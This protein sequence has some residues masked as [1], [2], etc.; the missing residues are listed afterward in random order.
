MFMGRSE[1]IPII[2]NVVDTGDYGHL[3]FIDFDQTRE[4][5]RTVQVQIIGE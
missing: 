3:Y 2:D 5:N 4:R 1:T